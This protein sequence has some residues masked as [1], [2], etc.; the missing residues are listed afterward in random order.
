MYA[1]CL[2]ALSAPLSLSKIAAE[3]RHAEMPWTSQVPLE[4]HKSHFPLE[5]ESTDD[6][7]N[8]LKIFCIG[9]ILKTLTYLHTTL[10]ITQNF[11]NYSM[12]PV[13]PHSQV[14][15]AVPLSDHSLNLDTLTVLHS[16]M[17]LRQLQF[18][19]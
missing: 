14:V 13:A 11:R 10:Q 8:H 19:L 9:A 7:K 15:L 12:S 1:Y 18:S 3:L 16:P 2:H 5:A 17:F 4:Y 6:S